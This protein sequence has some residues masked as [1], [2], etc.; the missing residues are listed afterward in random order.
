MQVK[1]INHL[2]FLLTMETINI[3]VEDHL[4]KCD[5]RNISQVQVKYINHLCFLL[6][7]ETIN[8]KVDDHL[9][10]CSKRKIL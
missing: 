5:K 8:I 3:N 4:Y 2:S 10:K 7:I 9:Y 1:Y 6:T